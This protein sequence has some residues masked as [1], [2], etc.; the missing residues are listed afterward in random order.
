M[1]KKEKPVNLKEHAYFGKFRS[2]SPDTLTE[3]DEARK[4][5]NQK[6]FFNVDYINRFC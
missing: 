4:A 1:L 5:A 2:P 6:W 3:E